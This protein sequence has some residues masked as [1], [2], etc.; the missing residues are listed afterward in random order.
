MN[1]V[2]I[3]I[4]LILIVEQIIIYGGFLNQVSEY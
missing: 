3:L 4:I 2:K 1:P